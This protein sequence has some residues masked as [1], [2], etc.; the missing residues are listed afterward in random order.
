MSVVI[1]TNFAASAAYNNLASTNKALQRS[2]TRLSSGMKIVQPSDDAGGL[3]VSMKLTAAIN[4]TDAAS[5]NIGNAQSFLQVQDGA[6]KT[7]GKILDRIS[8]LTTLYQDV[9]KSSSDK[10][11]YETEF[12]ALKEQLASIAAEK[13]NGVSIFSSSSSG[14]TLSVKIDEAGSQSVDITKANLNGTSGDVASVTGTSDLSSLTISTV[15]TAIQNVATSR[16]QNGAEFSRL[17]FANE[18]LT[19]NRQNLEAANSRISD[20]DV[21]RES[22][23]LARLS[24]LTQSGTAM[25]AQ[26]NSSSQIALRLLG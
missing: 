16:A 15:S 9:T 5:T 10:A 4:R 18:M 23:E 14:N 21:A 17:S 6:L 3:A 22:T 7:A 26:A 11:N 8:E 12:D 2:L 24:I 1:N 19:T 20:V 13:F 25:L